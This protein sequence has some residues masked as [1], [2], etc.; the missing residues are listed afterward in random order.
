MKL[1]T[2]LLI[3]L[4]TAVKSLLKRGKKVEGTE[5]SNIQ[6]DSS[7]TQADST[8]TPVSAVAL[9]ESGSA[10]SAQTGNSGN[11]SESPEPEPDTRSAAAT[12]TTSVTVVPPVTA[13]VTVATSGLLADVKSLLQAA[14]HDV[15][16]VWDDAVAFARKAAG[17][18]A[19][20]ADKLVSVLRVAGHDVA[21]IIGDAFSFARKH[22][23]S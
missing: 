1:L 21:E 12:V 5:N 18:E 8:A 3:A 7:L 6:S 10:E 4:S 11:G 16:A 23:K 22:G 13:A 2:R 9:P 19:E 15:E 20:L 14:G 17:E